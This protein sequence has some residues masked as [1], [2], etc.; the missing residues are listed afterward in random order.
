MDKNSILNP[1]NIKEYLM[2]LNLTM[3]LLLSDEFYEDGDSED[4]ENED[5]A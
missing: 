3:S 1:E 2:G 4:E 5:D